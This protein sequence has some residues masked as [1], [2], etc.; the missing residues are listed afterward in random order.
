[1]VKINKLEIENVKR[2]KAVQL[3]PNASGLTVIGGRNRQ[4]KT[5]VIDAIAWALGGDRFRP[6]AAQREGALTPPDLRVELDNGLIVERRGKNSELKVTDP[7]GRRGGQQL[8]N[9]FVEQLALDLPRFM[10]ASSREKANT[11]LQIIGLR[12]QLAAL[13]GQEQDLYNR[14]R[15]I[16]QIATQKAKYAEELP[17]DPSAPT[18]PV[19]VS[20]LIRQ[21]QEILARNGENQRKR[22]QAASLQAEE[23]RLRRQVAEMQQRLTEMQTRY[24]EVCRSLEIAQKSA[25]ALQDESTAELEANIANIEQLNRRVQS[26]LDRERALDEAAQYQAEYEG[27]SVALEKC[28]KEKLE[29]LAGAQ[30]PLPGLSVAEGELVY[31]GQRWDNMSASEQL[32]VAVAVVRRLNPKCGFVLLDKLEQ[33]DLPTLQE[34]GRWLEAEGL[35]VIATRVSCGGECS[36][37]I[38]D[39]YIK[40]PEQANEP[41][42]AKLDWKAGVF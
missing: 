37:I 40:E 13:E 11:L 41:A 6:S 16:G 29:L 2:I 12:E 22:A 42:Q 30:M 27:L 10:Q 4:G 34:F 26:N 35:Q 32:R 8:L 18:E 36:V 31:Q 9:E 1:M 17:F 21:Q 38:E 7:S 28:R 3:E 24:D 25:A 5:S 20:E 33:M 14:R 23:E 15:S 39:G 19:S